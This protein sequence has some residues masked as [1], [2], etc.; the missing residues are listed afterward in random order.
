ML[1]ACLRSARATIDRWVIVDTGSTDDTRAVVER[2]LEGI[3]GE[4]VE[5]KWIDFGYNRTELLALAS[6]GNRGDYLLWLDADCTVERHGSLPPLDGPGYMLRVTSAG[7]ESWMPMLVSAAQEWRFVGVAHEYLDG[8]L[9]LPTLD[10]LTVTHHQTEAT[11]AAKYERDRKLLEADLVLHPD[12]PRTVFY[13]ART[14]R[15]LGLGAQAQKLYDRRAEMGGSDEEVYQARLEA[16]ALQGSIPRLLAAWEGLPVRGEALWHALRLL[17]GRRMWRTAY[18][19]GWIGAQ[20]EQPPEHRLFVEPWV[21]E[22]GLRLEWSVACYWVGDYDECIDQ[23]AILMGAARLPDHVRDQVT[24]NIGLARRAMAQ[25]QRD[26]GPVPGAD[27]D[28]LARWYG[29]D[30]SSV[31]HGYARLYERHFRAGRRAVRTVLEIGVGGATSDTGYETPVGG[32]SL[33]VWRHYFP[34]ASVV[35]VD[36]Y[37][38][39]VAEDR[40]HFEQ[41]DQADKAFLAMLVEKYGPFD[42]VVDDGSHRGRDIIASFATLWDAVRP[43]GY[44]VIED[45]F[46]AYH[47]D[48]E[49]GPPGTPGT[50]AD[51]LKKLVDDTLLR[52]GS[53]FR[54]SIAAMHLYSNIVFLERTA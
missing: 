51:L 1:P 54:P 18:A 3:P 33:H 46:T 11:L 53:D 25:T 6:E 35:G 13:L 52:K 14:Y 16:G 44:Y 23:S 4:I 36:I 8:A 24:V 26:L 50:A 7:T 38:K 21:Y 17:N 29:T 31:K 27:L 5:R 40:I 22:W 41:G 20:L 43:G 39:D 37:R 30:K 10:A 49:G 32:Q 19:L 2:E 47:P 28:A 12:V 45:V 42:I 48:W 34:N 15:S 9:D